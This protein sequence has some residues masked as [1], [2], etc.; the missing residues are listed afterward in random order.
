MDSCLMFAGTPGGRPIED[1]GKHDCSEAQH[2]RKKSH[3]SESYGA[4]PTE[5]EPH[6]RRQ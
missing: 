1:H 6:L 4:R 5:A 2:R 3:I